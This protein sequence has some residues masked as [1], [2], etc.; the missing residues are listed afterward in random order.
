M[1]EEEQQ[2]PGIDF[3]VSQEQLDL[4]DINQTLAEV[5]SVECFDV[6]RCLTKLDGERPDEHLPALRLLAGLTSYHFD[7]DHST[8]PFKPMWIMADRRSLAP[9]D[10]SADQINVIAQFAPTVEHLGVRARLSDVSWFLQRQRNDMAARAVDAYCDSVEAVRDGHAKFSH[11]STSVWGIGAKKALVRAARISHATGWKLPA[12]QRVRTLLTDLVASAHQDRRADDFWRIAEV[13]LANRIS[14]PADIA[15]MAEEIAREEQLS[16]NP[17]QRLRLLQLAAFAFRIGRDENNANRCMVDAAECHVQKADLAD[18][19][20]LESAFLQDAIQVLRNYANT[21]ERREELTARLRAVQPGISD[22]MGHFST[23]IDLTEIVEHSVA[24]VRGHSWPV[25]LLSLVLCDQP[26]TPEQ[27]RQKAVDHAR[28]FPLQGMM[29]MQVH[30]FQGR[31]VFRAP[32]M[33]GDGDEPEN[34]LRYLMAFHRGVSRQVRVAGAIN[35]IRQIIA[36]EHPVSND[37]VLELLRDSPFIPMGHGY[38]YARAICHFLGGEYLE[39]VSLLTPQ[40]ENSLRHVLALKGHDTTTTDAN[41]IQ[42]EASLPILLNPDRPWRALLEETIPERYTHEIDLLFNFAGGPSVRNQVAHGK[43][44]AGSFW[45]NDFA[46]AAWLIIHLA[47][48]PLA[49]RWGNVEEIFA[50]VTG[51]HRMAEP[52]EESEQ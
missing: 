26:P 36:S 25:A 51:L 6:N 40:L 31:V 41:G 23:Q 50:R 12:S 5:D 20:M 33:G 52:S 3:V 18:S 4:F 16:K 24:S 28:D 32:G 8:E 29:P 1:C 42:T 38:I 43:V 17:E 9:A 7:P 48:I 49:P 14:P 46:Y 11:E 39:A 15:A 47:I 34:H 22:E 45:E 13:N 30:D 27:I 21:R 44:P 37:S 19:L 35:P 2:T 10:L